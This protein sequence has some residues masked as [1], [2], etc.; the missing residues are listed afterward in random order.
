M[1]NQSL[2]GPASPYYSTNIVENKF[3]DV[4]IARP[5]PQNP[6]DVYMVLSETYQYRPDLLAFDLYNDA[7]LWWVFAARNPNR[8][9][10]DP[11]FDFKAGVGIYVPTQTALTT[12]LGL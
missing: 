6:S 2:Y 3:L 10:P 4:M 1:S 8:L 12:A 9:G 11:Y 7:R 5:I